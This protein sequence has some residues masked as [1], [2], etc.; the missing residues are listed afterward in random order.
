MALQVV[1]EFLEYWELD[2]TLSILKLEADMVITPP[3]VAP[4]PRE[5][6]FSLIRVEHPADSFNCVYHL[7][8]TSVFVL[9]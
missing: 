1:A 7:S 3:G 9:V 5:Y 4:P 2:Q 6:S 8:N